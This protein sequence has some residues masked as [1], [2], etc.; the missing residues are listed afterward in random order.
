PESPDERR[1]RVAADRVEG[2]CN[3]VGETHDLISAAGG[4]YATEKFY[5]RN[6]QRK[7][8]GIL[9]FNRNGLRGIGSAVPRCR[10]TAVRTFLPGV[11]G[12]GNCFVLLLLLFLSR[13]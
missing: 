4:G 9:A 12:K 11:Y 1:H 7:R 5:G 13:Q 8:K 2:G 3:Y 10:L 6:S